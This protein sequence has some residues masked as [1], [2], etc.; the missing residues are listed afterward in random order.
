[1]FHCLHTEQRFFPPCSHWATSALS[2]NW[3][4]GGRNGLV[5]PSISVIWREFALRSDLRLLPHIS[6]L[7]L[8]SFLE[9]VWL[10]LGSGGSCHL[11]LQNFWKG[12]VLSGHLACLWEAPVVAAQCGAG[13]LCVS[14]APFS[15][16]WLFIAGK[17]FYLFMYWGLSL[18]I[19]ILFIL[20]NI[21][22]SKLQ[23]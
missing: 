7:S 15:T 6:A 10:S 2:T 16:W 19:L 13:D 17:W 5:A 14:A 1:M 21:C 4:G 23:K 3:E 22:S 9:P 11:V 8:K 20:F 12:W 18:K